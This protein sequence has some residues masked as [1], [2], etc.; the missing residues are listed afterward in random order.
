MLHKKELGPHARHF[1]ADRQGRVPESGDDWRHM[2][3]DHG[4]A[5]P[6]E[7]GISPEEKQRRLDYLDQQW[8]PQVI[9]RV[10]QQRETLEREHG[11]TFMKLWRECLRIKPSE[12]HGFE[13]EEMD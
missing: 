4:P 3:F 11:E 5:D 6:A 1:P 7:P 13:V 9:A 12:P 2:E 8:W 10:N